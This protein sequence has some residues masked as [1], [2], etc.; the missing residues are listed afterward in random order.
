M[1]DN[2]S[3][4]NKAT[5]EVLDF[6]EN[7]TTSITELHLKHS[8]TILILKLCGDLVRNLNGL[9][10][11][12]IEDNNGMVQALEV[13]TIL[14]GANFF[15]RIRHTSVTK[16]YHRSKFYVAPK[17][18]AIGT[19]WELK[20][21]K[22][23]GKILKIPRLIQT[24]FQYVSILETISMLFQCNE[25]RD[26]YF[27]RGTNTSVV[28]MHSREMIY[29]NFIPKVCNYKMRMT[30]LKSAIH[31]GRKRIVIKFVQFILQFKIYLN[32]SNQK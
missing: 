18:T 24:S 23:N 14:F 17:D 1:S 29:F 16:S 12:L 27:H 8:D 4:T 32:A 31:S 3:D 25:F 10:L 13:T 9:N 2:V 6:V 21:T 30:I 26:L 19:R 7:L 28:E 20:N 22:K 11:R 15:D 5:T